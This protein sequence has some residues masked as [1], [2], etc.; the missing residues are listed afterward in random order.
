MSCFYDKISN[1]KEIGDSMDVLIK[2]HQ[3]EGTITPPPS[4]S[5]LHRAI[6]CASLS[7]GKSVIKNILIGEDIQQTIEA[8][9][10]LGVQIEYIDNQLIIESTGELKFRENHQINCLESGSTLRF[11]IPLLLNPKGVEFYGQQTLLNRPLE[12]YE[13]IFSTQNNDFVRFKDY[14]YIQGDLKAE[15]YVVFD[16]SSSQYVSGLLFAL[17]LLKE[18]STIKLKENHQSIKYIHMTI[19]MLRQFGIKVIQNS[20]YDF[21]IPGNQTYKASD[22]TIEAD[23]SQASFFMVG[24]AINGKI[25]FNNLNKDSLQAD[26]LILFILKEAGANV[27]WTN[28]QLTISKNK[29]NLSFVDLSQIIDLGP[30]L[31]LMGGLS[32]KTTTF[33]N[34]ERLVYKESNRLKNILDILH[35]LDISFFKENGKISIHH[36]QNIDIKKISSYMDHRIAMTLA[37]IATISQSPTLIKH[38]EVINKSYP[39][40][41]NDLK[42]CGIDVEYINDGED[43]ESSN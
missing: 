15:D 12:Y 21:L 25:T 34:F 23:Y 13:Q 10:S 26:Q 38:I 5:Y 20:D 28:K 14:I 16:D 4:K 30:I 3:L 19:H 33:V 37:I 29:N 36:N 1:K 42:I 18:S 6:I 7:K 24:A 8:F 2:P 39:T 32:T 17:P 27:S 43:S 22:I 31:F 11:L 9:R 35:K 40:F 41:L